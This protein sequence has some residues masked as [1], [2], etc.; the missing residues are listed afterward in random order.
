MIFVVNLF[1]LLIEYIIVMNG[2]DLI[3]SLTISSIS[4]LSIFVTKGTYLRY[5]C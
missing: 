1:K 5:G 2:T 4:R 3:P